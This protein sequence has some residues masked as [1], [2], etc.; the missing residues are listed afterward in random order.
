MPHADMFRTPP[1]ASP[2]SRAHGWAL[3]LGA[4]LMVL[5]MAMHPTVHAHNMRGLA[6]GI[7]SGATFNRTIHGTLMVLT[8]LIL[9]GFAE[10]SNRLGWR[11]LPVLAAFVCY[12]AGWLAHL[13]AA[14]I[15]GFMVPALVEHMAEDRDASL[16]HL[17]PILDFCHVANQA[18]AQ[19]GVVAICVALVLWSAVLLTRAGGLRAVGILGFI[20]G[21]LPLFLLFAGRLPMDIHGFG[22]FVLALSTW[23]IAVAVQLIHDR[24]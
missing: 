4:I 9:L 22:G 21:G 6:D 17:S 1:D 12:A 2:S 10:L 15:N 3:G 24:I 11:Q 5:F 19:M 16:E 20:C 8:F 7:M 14:A 13:G 18:L 23:S